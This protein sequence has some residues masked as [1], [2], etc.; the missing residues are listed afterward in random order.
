MATIVNR[1]KQPVLQPI[2]RINFPQ[3][4]ISQLSNGIKVYQF[5]SGTQDVISIE[6][7]F[8]A[9]SWFQKKPFTAMATNLMLR[10]GTRNFSAQKLSETLDYYGAHFENT[11]ERDNAYITLYSLNKHLSKTLPLLSEIV[12]NPVF[13]EGE[14]SVVAGKQLQMLEVNRQKVNFLA[15]TH[16]NS[17][18]F[19][20]DHPYGIYLEPDDI[21]KVFT[22]DLVDFH[23]S[24]YHSGNCTIIAAGLI[25]PGLIDEL[26]T[27][28]GGDNWG[29]D[30]SDS[31]QYKLSGS[32]QKNHFHIK[33]GAMQ[34]AIR[35]GGMM[36]SRSH[37]D[38]AGMKV[39]NA[40]LGGY[41][42]SRLMNNLREDKGYTYGIGSSVVPLRNGGYFVISGEVGASVTKEALTEI[43]FELN[44]LCTDQ[45]GESEL[46]LVR[47]YLTGEMLRAVDGPFA[48]ADLYRELIEDDLDISHFEE[49][50]DTVQH[51]N[52]QQL[53]D[54]AVR[55]LNPDNLFTL[56]V[57]PEV[58]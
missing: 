54:L 40:I 20:N 56:V 25:K 29:G 27:H 46:S 4:E 53:Q 3:P 34:S 47:S 26:E 49:L 8:T 41:F 11:T 12:K 52:A 7:V 48:Q 21:S 19:G 16:F 58:I 36:F 32:D 42:G 22:T 45:V 13:P 37:R 2:G 43:K 9:G 23:K 35:I 38:F 55:Y 6:M 18:L 57:G 31:I 1:K 10:E 17:I 15:R 24:Q 44:R 33:E 39:L 14:F 50:I 51:I 28:F 30:N 5:N